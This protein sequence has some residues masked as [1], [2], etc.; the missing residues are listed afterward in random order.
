MKAN[1]VVPVYLNQTEGDTAAD[2]ARTWL[3]STAS[4]GVWEGSIHMLDIISLSGM[5]HML[6]LKI[7]KTQGCLGRAVAASVFKQHSQS[8]PPL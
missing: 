4:A 3:R 6:R 2:P 7:L 1:H 8:I 5:K